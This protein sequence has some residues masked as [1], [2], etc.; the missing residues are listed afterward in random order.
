MPGPWLLLALGLIFT[1]TG[2]PESCALLEAVQEEGAVTPDL[3]NVQIRPERR[4]LQKDLQRVRGDLGAAL[5]KYRG[6]GSYVNGLGEPPV[7]PLP[8]IS[9]DSLLATSSTG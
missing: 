3:G 7:I 5:G 9:S 6:E 1:L 8:G 4:F 2:V